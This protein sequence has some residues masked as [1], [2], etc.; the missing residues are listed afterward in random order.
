MSSFTLYNQSVEHPRSQLRGRTD[1]EGSGKNPKHFI[2]PPK[3]YSEIAR[4]VV[5]RQLADS[6]NLAY[7]NPTQ[8]EVW[9][10]E[11]CDVRVPEE[12]GHEASCEC[13]YNSVFKALAA[14]E[15]LMEGNK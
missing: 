9:H 5:A 1:K 6:V 8:G 10:R 3:G 12:N 14:C 2:Y 13:G 4:E 7:F 15:K 11:S